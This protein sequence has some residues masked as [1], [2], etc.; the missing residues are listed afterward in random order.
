MQEEL[1]LELLGRRKAGIPLAALIGSVDFLNLRLKVKPWV[2]IPRPETEQLVQRTLDELEGTPN[3]ILELGTGTGAIAIALALKFPQ[4]KIIATDLS[5]IALG[6]ARENAETLGALQH[7][8]FLKANLFDFK[9]SGELEGKVDLLISNP[10]YIP[11]ERLALLPE[12]VR[13]FDPPLSL[14]G[15]PDGF[16]V[17]ERILDGTSR[18]LAPRGLAAIEIDP[19]LEE[20]LKRYAKTSPLHFRTGVDTYGN[21][22]F[23]FVRL[24]V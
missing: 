16:R 10:P 9:G 7:I 4:A 13:S 24:T 22:R 18:F 23:L 17:V 14:N 2:F 6:L 15:G 8:N 3:V 21:L 1:F 5:P 12:E 20:P 11:T 19:L